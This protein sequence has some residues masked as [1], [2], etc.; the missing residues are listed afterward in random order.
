[1]AIPALAIVAV[2]AAYALAGKKKPGPDAA[3]DDAKIKIKLVKSGDVSKIKDALG[4]AVK[5]FTNEEIRAAVAENGV[6]AAAVALEEVAKRRKKRRRG[7]K[8]PRPEKKMRAATPAAAAKA[9]RQYLRGGGNFGTKSNPSR[10]VSRYQRRMGMAEKERDGIVGPKTRRRA[11]KYGVVL[12]L[13]GA[14]ATSERARNQ[15]RA[16]ID[17]AN[18]MALQDGS[19]KSA[20]EIKAEEDGHDKKQRRKRKRPKAAALALR[21]YLKKKGANFGSK[22]K[23]SRKVRRLQKK[24]RK[25]KADGIVGPKTRRRAK[26]LGVRLPRRRKTGAAVAP[27]PAPQPRPDPQDMPDAEDVARSPLE[28]AEDLRSYLQEP[29]ANFGT[30]AYPSSVVQEAQYDMG[31]PNPDG[32]V[33]PNTRAYARDQGVTLPPRS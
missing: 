18:N 19:E 21:T 24:M 1:M 3:A 5:E 12:P 13:R 9:L 27:K 14:A 23:R 25:I 17:F 26:A 16:T 31:D 4:D 29:G 33:G 15:N 28:A 22:R 6:E 30:G 11:K 7:R 20:G 32:I 2:A 8:K 10:K